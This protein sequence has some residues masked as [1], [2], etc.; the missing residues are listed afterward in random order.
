M[1]KLG[2]V[3]LLLAGI[4]VVSACGI[5]Q[6]DYDAVTAELS[7]AQADMS[8]LQ[9]DLDQL[10]VTSDMVR[11]HTT[12]EW[13]LLCVPASQYHRGEMITWRVRVIDPE[14]GNNL[15]ANPSEL[16]ADPPDADALAEMASAL[17]VTLHLSDGQSFPMRFGPHADADYFWTYGW[18]IP[19]DYPTGTLDEWV[20]AEWST[21]TE[22]KSGRTQPFQVFYAFLTILE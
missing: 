3:A 15:P 13:G 17:T 8:S 1:K 6:D 21:G 10:I 4:L 20:T 9:A 2:L 16:L 19:E 12:L 11:G 18:D 22:S 7:T 14:T 5:P